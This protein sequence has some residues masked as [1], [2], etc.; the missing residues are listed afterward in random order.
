MSTPS[1]DLIDVIRTIQK[2]KRTI[3]IITLVAVG[4]GGIFFAVKKKKYKAASHFLVNNPLYGDRQTLFRSFETRY[5]DYFGG[6]DDLDKVTALLNSDTVRERIIRN[7]QFQ[8]VYN[9]DINTEKG[10]A[11]LMSVFDKNFNVKRSEYKDIEVSY[12]A[13]DSVTAAN[14]ANMAVKVTEEVYRHYYTATKE[15]MAASIRNQV[16]QLDSS[17][18]LLTDSLANMR[19]RHNVYALISPSRQNINTSDMKGGGKGYG[20]AIEEIQNVESV[21]DQ[22]V[23]D[24]AHYISVL[25]EFSAS[26]GSSMEY[27]KVISRAHPPTGPSGTALNMVLIVAGCIGMFF[28]TLL[29][30]ILAYYRKLMAVPR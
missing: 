20:R 4:L 13:Y 14:V 12:I 19:D 18:N 17:I 3:I 22:L 23:M 8:I 26:S 1:F 30:L 28:S 9:A 11:F 2:Q 15:G 6:D 7:C 27:L 29:V 10:H 5:V 16:H 25:N 21:K 24:R